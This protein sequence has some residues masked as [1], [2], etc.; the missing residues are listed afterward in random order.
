MLFLDGDFFATR[1]QKT[2]TELYFDLVCTF[3]KHPV[4]Q[5][6]LAVEPLIETADVLVLGILRLSDQN[7]PAPGVLLTLN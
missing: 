4:F 3:A 2:E 5:Q 7:W 6:M 1:N